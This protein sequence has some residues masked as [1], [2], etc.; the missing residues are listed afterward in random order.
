MDNID[1]YFKIFGLKPDASFEEVKK[2]YRESI[3]VWTD[4]R[5][6][7]DPKIRREALL[8]I[9]EINISYEKI[10]SHF[11]ESLQK[12]SGAG[13]IPGTSITHQRASHD[14]S[15]RL[16]YYVIGFFIFFV[17]AGSIA[18]FFI[19]KHSKSWPE[20]IAETKEA[21]VMVKTPETVG[22]G[23][24]ISPDGMIL[25]SSH[26]VEDHFDDIEIHLGS[27]EI[28]KAYLVKHGIEPLDITILKIDGSD[29]NFLTLGDSDD[30]MEGEEVVSTGAPF[31]LSE[32]T[33]KGIVSKCNR[34]VTE[35]YKE[36]QY[37]Q[38]DAPISP[39]NSG[40]PLINSK[41]EV[42]GMLTLK[43]A[44]KGGEGLTF[45]IASNVIKDF[46]ENK[47]VILEERLRAEEELRQQEEESK[48]ESYKELTHV[49]LILKD[50]W[51]KEFASY[52]SE[53]EWMVSNRQIS[54]EEGRVMI[55]SSAA[56]PDGFY[57]VDEWL[58]SLTEKVVREEM[59][60]DEAVFLIRSSF[61]L[62]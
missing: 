1:P 57:S 5:L 54:A 31:A 40:G 47:L 35:E 45:A 4:K 6:S 44:E 43:I 53:I 22:S 59:T 51:I 55:S 7:P 46:K 14:S 28:K 3:R 34:V 29:Y 27:E 52:Y 26:L 56:P 17:I 15:S 20:I 49:Y 37:V 41:G 62:Y 50:V 13:E 21:I 36:I 48:Q 38:T 9:K 23:F 24:F 10:K 42:I 19:A 2:A 32:T 58:E 8:K 61:E 25:T 30:C 39:G 12:E 18:Y 60:V 16:L 11:W 33:T